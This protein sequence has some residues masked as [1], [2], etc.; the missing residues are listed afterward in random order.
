MQAAGTQTAALG[1]GGY[2]LVYLLHQRQKNTMVA[3]G[4][5]L[6]SLNTARTWL[7]GAG[8]QSAALAFGGI[9]VPAK[10]EQPKN[11]MEH[12]WTTSPVSMS[13]QQEMV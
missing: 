2:T 3:L 13:I 1:F 4:Q 6:T 12:S 7:S 8:T 9:L 10:Q 11:M 5:I